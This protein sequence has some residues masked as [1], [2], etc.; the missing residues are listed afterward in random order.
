MYHIM[1]NDT[2]LRSASNIECDF[3]IAMR[4]CHEILE[5]KFSQTTMGMRR[6]KSLKDDSIFA[7]YY[8]NDV[9]NALRIR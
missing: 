5:W 2:L 1:I 6:T 9:T 3:F 8:L 7:S 4:K